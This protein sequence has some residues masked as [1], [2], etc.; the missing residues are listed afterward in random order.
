MQVD[1]VKAQCIQLLHVLNPAKDILYSNC[2]L[3]TFKDALSL[4]SYSLVTPLPRSQKF[5]YEVM[6]TL[7]DKKAS[8][9]Y[10]PVGR[11]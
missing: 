6:L 1:N 5:P 4:H 8:D 10:K 9:V 3:K 11:K 2:T 7:A